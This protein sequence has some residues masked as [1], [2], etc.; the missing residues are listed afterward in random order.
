LRKRLGFFLACK[1]WK[2][3]VFALNEPL[4]SS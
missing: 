1:K 4:Q 2:T 3:H